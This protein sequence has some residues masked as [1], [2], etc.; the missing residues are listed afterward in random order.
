MTASAPAPATIPSP[1]PVATQPVAPAASTPAPATPAPATTES[2]YGTTDTS[3]DEGP[4][5]DGKGYGLAKGT[6]NTY[7][8]PGM[9]EM[10]AEEYRAKLQES[11]SA[12]QALRRQE[13]LKARD[14]KIGNA[15]SQSYLDG[16]SKKGELIFR[17]VSKSLSS[18]SSVQK[19]QAVNEDLINERRVADTIILKTEEEVK[20]EEG[21]TEEDENDDTEEEVKAS[22]NVEQQSSKDDGKQKIVQDLS[23]DN[24]TGLKAVITKLE[25]SKTQKDVVRRSEWQTSSP[26]P[27]TSEEVGAAEQTE[28]Y[29]LGQSSGY[30]V[31]NDNTRRQNPILGI[32]PSKKYAQVQDRTGSTTQRTASARVETLFDKNS[33][34]AIRNSPL[35]SQAAAQS[36]AA[37]EMDQ[38]Q[39]PTRSSESPSYETVSGR[40]TVG[41][42][43]KKNNSSSTAPSTTTSL[44]ESE[45]SL[46]PTPG[47]E[48]PKYHKI[49]DRRSVG[50]VRKSASKVQPSNPSISSLVGS[51]QRQRPTPKTQ[52]S[53]T[54]VADVQ[55]FAGDLR[56]TSNK[57]LP[58]SSARRSLIQTEQ[59]SRPRVSSNLPPHAQ[60]RDQRSVGDFRDPA[61]RKPLSSPT[62]LA[63]SEVRTRPTP[64]AS[65]KDND[66]SDS[67]GV[68]FK[69]KASDSSVNTSPSL[70]ADEVR[71]RPLASTNSK[72][73]DVSDSRG[74]IFK[75]KPSDSSVN[76]VPSL[77]ADE[78]RQRP[79][80]SQGSK[81]ASASDSRGVIFKT[82]S[83]GHEH[84]TTASLIADEVRQRP[85]LSPRPKDASVSDSRGVV[86]KSSSSGHEHETTSSLIADEVR[87]RPPLSPR[88]KD[89]SVSDSRGV[90]FKSSPPSSSSVSSAT[91][92]I[93]EERRQRKPASST[94]SR[95]FAQVEDRTGDAR[96]AAK[97]TIP[98]PP[99]PK[100]FVA[101][102]QTR[103]RA[104]T[105]PRKY[106][107]V[108][109]RVGPDMRR[110]AKEKTEDEAVE[111]KSNW[112][113]EKTQRPRTIPS[114]RPEVLERDTQT[115]SSQ[116]R[117]SHIEEEKLRREQET[118]QVPIA[119]LQPSSLKALVKEDR[120]EEEE[121]HSKPPTLKMLLNSERPISGVKETPQK[122]ISAESQLKALLK[123]DEGKGELNEK[124]QK[125]PPDAGDEW[126]NEKSSRPKGYAKH[127]QSMNTSYESRESHLRDYGDVVNQP[128]SDSTEEEDVHDEDIS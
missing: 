66:V 30:F 127:S 110:P 29:S 51:E 69:T 72:E 28:R 10:S 73:K 71:Q 60:V 6:A 15:N 75:K 90:V 115:Q 44:V 14:G 118:F 105:D 65:G 99:P 124:R 5:F 114:K 22:L 119:E 83:S 54:S 9:E 103:P 37:N 59:R 33:V 102:K 120:H 7:A 26:A 80:A 121:K 32:D 2:G 62:S 53:S 25:K 12:R 100:P 35:K 43:R 92:L 79:I 84:Q 23:E 122:A 107:R 58:A 91:S 47:T 11:I 128:G 45:V 87:Q 86:Y 64:S 55:T 50:D 112:W 38:T 42:L 95:K 3:L 49:E 57:P 77:I 21:S 108:E 52:S 101:D 17:A 18:S 78:V 48:V 81:D 27:D 116:V 125:R 1:A 39:R 74:V 89:T 4:A 46:R 13:S 16:L 126:W 111:E 61:T 123:E 106:A 96:V 56:K 67:R 34:G 19:S 104:S 8:L 20:N 68:I 94:S 98:Q 82:S 36:L 24:D 31:R 85:P 70:I 93:E 88:S 76:T 109:N 117:K 113:H 63:Q 40:T 97:K 41:D